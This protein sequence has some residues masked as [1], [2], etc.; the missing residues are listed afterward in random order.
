MSA[1]DIDRL[2]TIGGSWFKKAEKAA[3]TATLP[4]DWCQWIYQNAP[5]DVRQEW[6]HRHGWFGYAVSRREAEDAA[7]LAFTGLPP[8][9]RAE[10]L[11]APSPDTGEPASKQSTAKRPKGK[12]R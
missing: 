3:R 4:P 11:T 1:D 2:A 8:A 7:A 10:L 5:A 9:R 6:N 12:K